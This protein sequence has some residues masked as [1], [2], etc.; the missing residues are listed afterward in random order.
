MPGVHIS[1]RRSYKI[2]TN[3]QEKISLIKQ[4]LGGKQF[5]AV[6]L[7]LVVLFAIPLTIYLV[8]QRQEIRSKASTGAATVSFGATDLGSKNIGESFAPFDILLSAEQNNVTGV[9]ITVTFDDTLTATFTPP[10]SSGSNIFDYTVI[11]SA[12]YPNSVNNSG[13]SRTIRYVAVNK[14]K[15]N[16]VNGPAIVLGKITFTAAK[17]TA[18]GTHQIQFG[19]VYVV[20]AGQKDK[21]NVTKDAV[22][23]YTVAVPPAR[24]DGGWTTDWGSCSATA[25]GTS[26]TQTRTCTNPAPANGGAACSGAS[27][28]TCSASCQQVSG[29]ADGN[30]CVDNADRLQWVRERNGDCHRCTNWSSETAPRR[31][32]GQDYTLWYTA[33]ASKPSLCTTATVPNCTTIACQ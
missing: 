2:L 18:T 32:Y 9:D 11:P 15:N 26:G 7:V 5:V 28:Q 27:S 3:L 29:D 14:S 23:T 31:N 17:L 13:S 10:A 12:K 21:L 22:V 1:L 30:N 6:F 8:K 4:S 24:V 19:D 20:A 25:C 16:S 33:F